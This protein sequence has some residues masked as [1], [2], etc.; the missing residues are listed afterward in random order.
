MSCGNDSI[1]QGAKTQNLE[2]KKNK[3]VASKFYDSV[4]IKEQMK[5]DD[6]DQ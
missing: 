2:E 5:C 4:Y 6:C 3:K 1:D